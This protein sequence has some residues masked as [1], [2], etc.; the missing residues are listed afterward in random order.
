MY[1]HLLALLYSHNDQCRMCNGDSEIQPAFYAT[2]LDETV[3]KLVTNIPRVFISLVSPLSVSI[4][5]SVVAG[6]CPQLHAKACPCPYQSEAWAAQIKEDV[7]SFR[8]TLRALQNKYQSN[9]YAVVNQPFLEQATVPLGNDGNGDRSFLAPDC[10][11]FS[12]KA[13]SAAAQ[14]Y[15]T[16]LLEP[17]NKKSTS[18]DASKP[19]AC[20]SA[21]QPFLCTAT[22]NCGLPEKSGVFVGEDSQ[23]AAPATSSSSAV[24]FVGVGAV[25]GVLVLVVA[26]ALIIQRKAHAGYSPLN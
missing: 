24:V 18:W 2:A 21:S 15:W 6:L 16:N 8:N 23:A 13:H 5:D 7:T 19:L 20:P 1:C 10:F 9:T 11:H 3:N 17:V 14:A 12:A 25:V 26:V 4:L 22:N